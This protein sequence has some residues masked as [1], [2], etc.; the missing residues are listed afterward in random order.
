M[1]GGTIHR[2]RNQTPPES[3]EGAGS[4]L[5]VLDRAFMRGEAW[6]ERSRR[7]MPQLSEMKSIN[8]LNLEP[9]SPE[10]G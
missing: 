2:L 1:V 9:E 5:P 3:S 6:N 7:R 4:F 8:A 10:K